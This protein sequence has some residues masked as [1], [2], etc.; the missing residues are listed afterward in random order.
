MR[1]RRTVPEKL[2][3]SRLGNL[4]Y[5]YNLIIIIFIIIIIDQLFKFE[6]LN[7]SDFAYFN[8]KTE[9]LTNNGG[10]V[11]EKKIQAKFGPNL[12]LVSKLFLSP[13]SFSKLLLIRLFFHFTYYYDR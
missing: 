6:S 13:N 7:F 1:L 10:L 8:R 4:E 5:K 3:S 2:D 12:D 11:S 9:Y